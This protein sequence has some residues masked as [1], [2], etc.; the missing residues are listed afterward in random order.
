MINEE[1]IDNIPATN[2]NNPLPQLNEKILVT[3]GNRKLQLSHQNIGG[4]YGEM[5]GKAL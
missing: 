4:M 5:L 3:K 2:L 1:N